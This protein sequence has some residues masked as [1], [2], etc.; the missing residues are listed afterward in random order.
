MPEDQFTEWKEQ[1]Q[2]DN[3]ETICAFANTRGGV[4]YI[5][6]NDEGH[7]V[8]V[9]NL[10]QLLVEIPNLILA[11]LNIVVDV[12][13]EENDEG[14]Y[15][16]IKVPAYPQVVI[17]RGHVFYRSGSTTQELRGNALE[18]LMLRKHGISWDE[19]T[20]PDVSVDDLDEHAFEYFRR[21][22]VL[23]HREQPSFLQ[24]TRLAI[25]HNLSL[26]R[27]GLLT[28]AAILLFHPRPQRYIV[29]YRILLTYLQNTVPIHE[30]Q[31]DG[32]LFG[33]VDRFMQM[34]DGKYLSFQPPAADDDNDNRLGWLPAPVMHEAIL[35]AIIHNAYA[36]RTPIQL[37]IHDRRLRLFN[38]AIPPFSWTWETLLDANVTCPPNPLIAQA[39][40]R[41]GETSNWGRGLT[42]MRET[43]LQAGLEPPHI[44]FAGGFDLRY[45]LG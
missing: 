7:V 16:C 42:L 11:R 12:N 19:E 29:G 31:L 6:M 15:I 38:C 45:T 26:I 2:N 17:T 34:I 4:M 8:P 23:T 33:I 24:E 40:Y 35:N 36:N 22:A 27:A 41:A 18:M 32:P 13:L 10:R 44:G 14:E 43:S 20:I 5:G 28:R 39:F 25:L 21:K 3:L 1:W 9:K 37:K 30:E